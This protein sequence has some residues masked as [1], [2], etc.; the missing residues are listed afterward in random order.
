MNNKEKNQ[1]KSNNKNNI[2]LKGSNIPKGKRP[3]K[4]IK[5]K[6]LEDHNCK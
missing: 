3:K 4:N 1:I 5:A 6:K 2:S